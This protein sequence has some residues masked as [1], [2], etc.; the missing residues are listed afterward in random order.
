MSVGSII[1]IIFYVFLIVLLVFPKSKMYL[2]EHRELA[3]AILYTYLV[4]WFGRIMLS[5]STIQNILTNM[6]T[7]GL[8]LF[9]LLFYVCVPAFFLYKAIQNYIAYYVKRKEEPKEIKEAIIV[10]KTEVKGKN[11]NARKRK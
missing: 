2:R 1:M 8:Y 3:T 10:E 7:N 11:K 6:K 9:L 4:V 5:R